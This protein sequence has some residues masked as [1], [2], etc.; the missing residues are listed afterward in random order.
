[1]KMLSLPA[2]FTHLDITDE[3]RLQLLRQ[4]GMPRALMGLPVVVDETMPKDELI[5]RFPDG[6]RVR[7]KVQELPEE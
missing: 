2:D 3:W 5:L 6:R 4:L 7:V 1:M